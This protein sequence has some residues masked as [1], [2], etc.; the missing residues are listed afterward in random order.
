M[1]NLQSRRMRS[2]VVAGAVGLAILTPA[3]VAAADS[4]VSAAPPLA[5][6]L[7]PDTI[8]PA[9]VDGSAGVQPNAVTYEVN[10]WG[11]SSEAQNPHPSGHYPGTVAAVA[12]HS[13]TGYF[14]IDRRISTYPDRQSLEAWLY[15]QSCFLFICSWNQADHWASGVVSSSVAIKIVHTLA[16]NCANGNAT[17]WRLVAAGTSYGFNGSQ[18]ATYSSTAGNI[19]TIACGR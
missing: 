1:W 17:Q 19:Q 8:E 18:Y 11:C 7:R 12:V 15:Y 16:A 6:S 9:T 13:C 3:S 2:A 14:G 10:P 4:T 5:A